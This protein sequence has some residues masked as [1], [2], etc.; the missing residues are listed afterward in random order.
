LAVPLA[1]DVSAEV[2]FADEAAFGSPVVVPGDAA[3]HPTISA[4]EA[5]KA[6]APIVRL[7]PAVKLEARGS[8]S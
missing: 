4:K 2:S 1:V 3:E 6:T 7:A 8:V 5:A